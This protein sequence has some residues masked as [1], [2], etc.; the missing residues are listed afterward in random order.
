MLTVCYICMLDHENNFISPCN[1][2]GFFFT[3][4]ILSVILIAYCEKYLVKI[5]SKYNI[6]L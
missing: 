5:S 3:T 1:C 4:Y 6:Y 2:K